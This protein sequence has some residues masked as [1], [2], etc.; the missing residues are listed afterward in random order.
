[1]GEFIYIQKDLQLIFFSYVE[2]TLIP[3]I[4]QAY[5][6]P[7]LWEYLEVEADNMSNYRCPV[8]LPWHRHLPVDKIKIECNVCYHRF[9]YIQFVSQSETSIYLSHKIYRS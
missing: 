3:S 8:H 6:W 5:R 4:L 7:G 1:V 2:K 9:V